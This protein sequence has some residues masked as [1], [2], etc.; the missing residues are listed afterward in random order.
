MEFNFD[1]AKIPLKDA[2]SSEANVLVI[3]DDSGSMDWAVMTDG[4]EGEFWLTNAGI[5]DTQVGTATTAYQYLVP[6]T[7]NV[8]GNSSILPTEEALAADPAFSTNNYGTWRAWNSQ[9]NTVYYNPQVR[10]L[11]WVGLNRNNVE[12]PNV[13]P[14]AAPLD[15][16]DA[17]IQT[18]NLTTPITY[19]RQRADRKWHV[20]IFEEPDQQRRLPSALL[21]D[22]GDGSPGLGRAA[23]PG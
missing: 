2:I 10:Y 19:I 5:K 14:T 21:R 15:P 3:M 9:Y 22:D 12:F 8:Y 1:L 20:G 13:L 18:I 16:Y 23:Y 7:T 11:P 17:V 6:L 4:A